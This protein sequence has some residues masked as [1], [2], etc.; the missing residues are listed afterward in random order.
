M[1]HTRARQLACPRVLSSRPIREFDPYR[2]NVLTQVWRVVFM[3]CAK[4]HLDGKLGRE[5]TRERDEQREFDEAVRRFESAQQAE[6][7]APNP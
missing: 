5:A 1:P 2:L 4:A 7:T 3:I 6:R